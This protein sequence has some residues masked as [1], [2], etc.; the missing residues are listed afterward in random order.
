VTDAVVSDSNPDGRLTN[1]DLEMAGVLL[2]EAVLEA[3]IGPSAMIATQTA[4]GCDNLPA[5]AWT[6]RMA[7]RSASP[8]SYR[9]LRGLAMRQRLTRSAPPAVFHIAGVQNTMADVMS[10]AVK[11]VTTPFHLLDQS[12]IAM[13]P[14]TFLTLFNASDAALDQCPAAFRPLVQRDLNAAW[15][16]TATAT[17]DDHA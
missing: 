8:V 12:P 14:E 7:S 3:T 5:V 17:V 6:S 10:R 9:L 1:S 4:I 15:A 16:A 2:Q 11:G 13:C